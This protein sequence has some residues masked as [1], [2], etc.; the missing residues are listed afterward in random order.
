MKKATLTPNLTLPV[1]ADV[2]HIDR[3]SMCRNG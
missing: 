3:M 1:V 2:Q